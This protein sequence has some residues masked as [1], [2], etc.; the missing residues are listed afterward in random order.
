MIIGGNMTLNNEVEY[1]RIFVGNVP[2]NSWVQYPSLP[3]AMSGNFWGRG[4]VTSFDKMGQ[5]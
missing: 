3:V 4:A 1:D 2:L 5:R